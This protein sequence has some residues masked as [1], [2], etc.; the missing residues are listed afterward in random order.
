MFRNSVRFLFLGDNTQ[1]FI[2][3]GLAWTL[4]AEGYNQLQRLASVCPVYRILT[5]IFHFYVTDYSQKI[6]VMVDGRLDQF[7]KFQLRAN[8]DVL[9]ARVEYFLLHQE[10]QGGRYPSDVVEQRP[11]GP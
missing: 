3:R 7:G 2:P 9:L 1:L 11:V 8:D 4:L 6:N 5:G 10:A